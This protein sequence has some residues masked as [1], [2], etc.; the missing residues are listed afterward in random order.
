[1]EGL[2]RPFSITEMWD[3]ISS[4]KNNKS[5][6][7]DGMSIEFYKSVFETRGVYSSHFAEKVPGKKISVINVFLKSSLKIQEKYS[8][9]P[10][11]FAFIDVFQ[12]S[13]PKIHKKC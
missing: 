11:N 2:T 8:K 6:G 12:K 5:P 7:P 4:F 13:S 10:G 9:C 3:A 1:M